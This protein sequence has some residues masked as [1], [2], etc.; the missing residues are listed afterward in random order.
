MPMTSLKLLTWRN[1]A[2]P[3]ALDI[4]LSKKKPPDTKVRTNVKLHGKKNLFYK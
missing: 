2:H 1:A 4:K 3:G